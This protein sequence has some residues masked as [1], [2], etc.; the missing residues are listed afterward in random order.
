MKS[1]YEV[2]VSNL[3]IVL[4]TFVKKEAHK[5]FVDYSLASADSRGRVG[6]ESVTLLK[7]G[8]IVRE[9]APRE[10]EEES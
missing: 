3:G 5:R 10:E 1:V 7:D 4:S 9:Y 6:G 2:V 8:E